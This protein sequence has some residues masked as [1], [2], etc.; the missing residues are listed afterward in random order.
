MDEVVYV[1][2]PQPPPLSPRPLRVLVQTLTHL[3]PSDKLI[4]KAR[5]DPYGD[6]VFSMLDRMCRFTWD[7]GFIPGCQRW[8]SYGDDELGYNHRLCFFL[9]DYGESENDEDVPVR[10]FEWDGQQFK[11]MPQLLRNAAVRE[12]L[13]NY[14]FTRPPPSGVPRVREPEPVRKSVRGRLRA[15]ER[16]PD[17]ELVHLKEHP[18]DMEWLKRK[19]R[20]RFY[21]R[22]VSEME[23]RLKEDD[24]MESCLKE[25]DEMESRLEEGDRDGN[26]ETEQPRARYIS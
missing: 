4:G 17:H 1:L 14:P 22:L 25:D 26:P 20:P 10:C 18:E 9:V 21:A 5:E 6:K 13:T 2:P 16:I 7:V 15:T 23:S 19:L 11:P 8:S 3:V 24:E 12:E